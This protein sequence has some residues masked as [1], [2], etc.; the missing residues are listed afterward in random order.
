M[1]KSYLSLLFSIFFFSFTQSLFSQDDQYDAVYLKI[2]KTY[3]LNADG[4]MD[5][6]YVKQIKLQ[7]YRSFNSLYGE[8]FVVYNPAFQT[9]KI[10]EVYTVM[11]DGKKV[12]S[13]SNAFN[14]VLPSYAANAPAYNNLR[15]MVVTHPGTEIGAVLYLDYTLHTKNGFYPALMGNELLAETEPVKSLVVNVRVPKGMKLNYA[16]L[17][18]K[19]PGSVAKGADFD[20]YS[21]QFDNVPAISAEENQKSGYELYPRLIFSTAKDR[22]TLYVGFL[23]NGEKAGEAKTSIPS[24]QAFVDIITK[25]SKEELPTILKI[26]EKVFNEFR[27]WP[28]PMRYTGFQVRGPEA[29]WKSNGGTLAEKALLLQSMLNLAGFTAQ[30]VLVVKK[31]VYDEKVGNL[32]DID[33]I[34]VKVKGKNT[35]ELFLSVSSLNPQNL[36]YTSP[37]KIFVVLNGQGKP[38]VIETKEN[39]GKILC[40]ANLSITDKKQFKGEVSAAFY[41]SSNPWF[42]WL[43]DRT[44]SKSYFGGFSA[45]DL[46]ELVVITT[47]PEESN[48]RYS[49]EK[50][51]PFHKDTN[52]YFYSLPAVTNGIDSWGYKV[53]PRTRVSTFEIPSVIDETYELEFT[54]P[55]GLKLFTQEGKT[56]VGNNEGKFT[57]AVSKKGNTVKVIRSIKLTKRVIEPA[58]YAD[59]KALMDRWNSGKN[60]EIVFSE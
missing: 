15:E 60:K 24:M 45:S 55:D 46:K 16:A 44:K 48:A 47:G 12:P 21:W 36:I 26:Q 4:S 28:I 42:V 23:S 56:E 32:M 14:E 57:F 19:N 6:N 54:L 50:E 13:P 49:V 33:D 18:T 7:T 1:K 9:L 31:P 11:A 53:F 10:N 39:E 27:L 17:N 8:T 59:F 20:T 5:Y 43:K 37:D 3:T 25:E 41:T 29:T 40:K 30:P 58:D 34:L 51:K 52:F 2:A 22:E 35:D 38:A